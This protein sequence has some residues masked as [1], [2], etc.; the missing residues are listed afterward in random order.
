MPAILQPLFRFPVCSSS[1]LFMCFL[2]P[3]CKCVFNV[4]SL[5]VHG[6]QEGHSRGSWAR[7]GEERSQ[8]SRASQLTSRVTTF[9]SSTDLYSLEV[10]ECLTSL[11]DKTKKDYEPWPALVLSAWVTETAFQ[12]NLKPTTWLKHKTLNETRKKPDEVEIW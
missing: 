11:L 6:V 2:L 3:F 9:L 1:C 8:G 10:E 5:L 7:L 12:M 4:L